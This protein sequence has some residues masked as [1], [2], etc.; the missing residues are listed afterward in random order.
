[1]SSEKTVPEEY[2]H[3]S[4]ALASLGIPME[5]ALDGLLRL[6]AGQLEWLA[7]KLLAPRFG[8]LPEG[9]DF[10]VGL[11]KGLKRHH[12]RLAPA[13][14]KGFVRN[15]FVNEFLQGARPRERMRNRTGGYAP[16]LMV[17]SP[18]MRCN[19]R[20]HGCY[21]AYYPTDE[22][23]TTA[24][25]DD[26][27][28]QA[29]A[30]GMYLFVISGGEPFM[31][32]DLFDLF[33]R[34]NDALFLTY[35][36]G[37]LLTSDG[38][39][40]RLAKLGNVLPAISVEGFEEHTD[41]RRGK[42]VHRRI[43]AAMEELR[44]AGVIFGF[45]ATPTRPNNDLLVSDEFVDF[46]V[47]QGCFFGFFFQ[48]MPVGRSPDLELMTTPEQRE[49]R[50]RRVHKLRQRKPIVLA[51]FWCD[52][53]LVDGC[54]SAGNEYFHVNSRGGI[55]PCVFNQFSVDNVRTTRLADA[56]DSPY[57]RYLRG[58]LAEVDNL[59]RPCPII[60]RPQILRD[61]VEK[62]NPKC[63]QAGG[64]ETV[65]ALAPGLNDYARRLQ[66]LL[67]P[68]WEKEYRGRRE[69]GTHFHIERCPRAKLCARVQDQEAAN[70][71]E[72]AQA[73]QGSH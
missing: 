70:E 66:A 41:G 58:R 23:L 38:R 53:A 24:E 3:P 1:M 30:L 68:V 21:S 36:N 15:F 18:T 57:F 46:Y 55:E 6:P 69:V 65:T 35:T 22:E 13:V 12:Q 39:I 11:V 20:C 27:F 54:L 26:L 19:L 49:Y 71:A 59:L 33:E 8:Y 56:I 63:S 62:F 31:R 45:S 25:L 60:D 4:R 47:E 28:T 72:D 48:Y 10:V 50:R 67:D 40:D 73:A 34:H 5:L 17:V 32:K 37:T 43:L 42:G 7:R 16:E 2:S 51:D 44:R 61:S 14:R 64:E 52:G 29:K 9:L